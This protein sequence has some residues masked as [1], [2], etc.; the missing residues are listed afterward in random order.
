M[1]LSEKKTLYLLL[2]E[3]MSDLLDQ[4]NENVK[5]QEDRKKNGWK[6]SNC[7]ITGVKAQF[8]HARCISRKLEIDIE[9]NMMT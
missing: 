6:L 1:N 3:Y 7:S 2:N 9:Q 8:N 4:D 5:R